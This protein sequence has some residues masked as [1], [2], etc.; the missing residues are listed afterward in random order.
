MLT[1]NPRIL[2]YVTYPYVYKDD[3]F[4]K[5]ELTRIKDFCN[6]QG[7]EKAEVVGKFG[8]PVN[9]ESLRNSD[10]KMHGFNNENSWIFDKLFS[11]A[12]AINNQYYGYDLT[13]FGYFQYTEY[14]NPGSEYG[15]HSDMIMGENIPPGMELPRKLSFSLI[16]SDPTEYEGGAFEF[17]INGIDR[18]ILPQNY[19][20]VLAFPSYIIHRIAPL[21]SGS[22]KSLVFWAVGPKFK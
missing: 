7:T 18:I 19:G 11:V 21:I 16:L 9:V 8:G 12:D 14:N 3:F 17:L 10:I 1:S 22:R 20:R 2:N 4:T 13:G 5:E 15:Y 6:S